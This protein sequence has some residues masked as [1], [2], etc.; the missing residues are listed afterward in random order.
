MVKKPSRHRVLTVLHVQHRRRNCMLSPGRLNCGDVRRA[1][2]GQSRTWLKNQGSVVCLSEI[3]LSQAGLHEEN[4]FNLASISNAVI[5]VLSWKPTEQNGF[6]KEVYQN[7]RTAGNNSVTHVTLKLRRR[8][9]FPSTFES[10]QITILSSH[11]TEV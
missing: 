7:H 3:P 10:A 6:K 11:I 9:S 2:Q 4:R 8:K 5:I 1:G